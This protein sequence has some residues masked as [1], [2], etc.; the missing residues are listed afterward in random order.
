MIVHYDESILAYIASIRNYYKLDSSY[1]SNIA[2][3]NI[4]KERNPKKIFLILI[5]GMGSKLIEKK[6][7]EDSFLRK[8]MLFRTTSV[9]PP[10]TT[11]AT[12]SIL[13][14]KAPNENGW[15]GWMQYIP[16]IDD[17]II[18][19]RG[20]AYY[21]ESV[22]Y[23][24]DYM[25]NLIPVQ[26]IENELNNNGIKALT[27]NPSF[28]PSGCHSVDEM[29]ERLKRYSHSDEYDFIYAYY[30][31][32]DSLMHEHGPSS[33]ICDDYLK[34]VNDVLEDLS[35]QLPEDIMMVVVADHGQ[36]DV[37]RTYNLY[38]SKYMKYLIRRPYIENRAVALDIFPQM[39]EEFMKEFIEEFEN[40]FILLTKK[41]VLESKLF[42][43]KEDHPHLESLLGDFLAIG[44]SDMIIV[45]DEK[46]EVTIKGQHA[47]ICEDE[48][49]IP[50][51]IY[52][53]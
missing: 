52:Q 16:E 23:G 27:I 53:K 49:M 19:F 13:N 34:H 50:V 44:K 35:Q 11:A 17:I 48:L 30:D 33:Q 37:K 3:D 47:G 26:R 45:Y 24:G 9:F 32:Y 14:G 28:D 42:G 36:I 21:D 38:N 41:Q 4:L 8:N 6:L 46:N 2:F 29:V 40:E 5:D 15:L 12:T 1:H 20:V 18:P 43:E 10:T 22:N 25:Y 7:P 51:I 31:E 39:H